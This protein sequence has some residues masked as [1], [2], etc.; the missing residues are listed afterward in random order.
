M[1]CSMIGGFLGS[2]V[3]YDADRWIPGRLFMQPGSEDSLHDEALS[4]RIAAL[5]LL[6]LKLEHLD[7]HVGEEAKEWVEGVVKACGEGM[8]CL[9]LG[10]FLTKMGLS[11]VVAA[12]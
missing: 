2:L 8:C 1:F 7:V 11:S 4:T 12:E 5:K 6:N 9:L 10:F 3:C